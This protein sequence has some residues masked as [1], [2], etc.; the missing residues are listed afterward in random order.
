[1]DFN[2]VTF[3]RAYNYGAVL[4][5][6]AL[7]SFITQMGY[8]CSIYDYLSP[9]ENQAIGIKGKILRAIQML[10]KKDCVA[11]EKKY[12][13]FV[14]TALHL[15]KETNSKIYISGSD[16][17]WNPTNGIDSNYFLQFASTDS[18]KISYAASMGEYTINEEQTDILRK[19]LSDFD[20]VSVREEHDKQ[21]LAE[22]CDK[23]IL[24]HV[25]PTLLHDQ[26]FWYQQACP[27][28]GVPEKY[29]LVYLM[30]WPKNV[31]KLLTWLKKETGAKIL[32]VDGQGIIQGITTNLIKHNVAK[33]RVAPREF[34][35][36]FAHAEY[37]VTSSFHGTVFSLLFEKE[38]YAIT[39]PNRA[40]RIT[41][42]LNKVGLQSVSE[43]AQ[44][45]TR[46][47]DIDWRKVETILKEERQRSKD[48]LEKA[49]RAYQ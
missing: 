30:H 49:Y 4:Q 35:W 41:N 44:T 12:R 34:L 37:V 7:Q 13:A 19:Y 36:L 20:M 48:Y 40:S 11:R 10:N 25:D 17:V 6:Y 15:N 45:F 33:H 42:I 8:S 46:N 5:A 39:D 18:V 1:M 9:K 23:E 47:K 28:E 14:E 21:R 26:A 31:N 38:F 3:H 27:V 16:Q 22:L 32:I 29:I 2:I 24:V 43:F